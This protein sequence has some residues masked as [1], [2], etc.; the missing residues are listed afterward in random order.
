MNVKKKERKNRE[1]EGK[2]KRKNFSEWVKVYNRE[3]ERR[4][5][6]K[7]EEII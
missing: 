2:K 6:E 5:G 4:E 7:K 1:N 3:E